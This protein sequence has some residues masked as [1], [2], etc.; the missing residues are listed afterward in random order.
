MDARIINGDVGRKNVVFGI[1]LFLLLGVAVGIP[2]TIDFF[3]GSVLAEEQYRI[4]KVIHGYG[5]FLGFINYFFG[6][7]IDRLLLTR[8]QKEV[9]SWSFLLAGAFGGLGRMGLALF[10]ALP[11]FGI[12]ASLGEVVFIT[13]GTLIFVFGQLRGR[14]GAVMVHQA[15]ERRRLV[16]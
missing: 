15:V 2:L 10:S 12:Y 5:I 1:G 14:S 9:S 11:T 4:W 3:G 8:A 7:S 16:A 13:L 6:L